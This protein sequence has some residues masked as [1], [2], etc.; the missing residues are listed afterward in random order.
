MAGSILE[1]GGTM[2]H[3]LAASVLVAAC[4]GVATTAADAAQGCGHGW[5]RN[6][7][8]YCVRSHRVVYM[9]PPPPPMPVYR[10]TILAPARTGLIP[11]SAKSAHSVCSYN[12]HPNANGDCVPN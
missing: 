8:G 10:Q 11:G 5:H 12:Y 6:Y 9:P 4:I 3:L 7:H 1:F 2:R